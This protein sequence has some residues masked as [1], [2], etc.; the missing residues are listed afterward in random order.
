MWEALSWLVQ[1]TAVP[2]ETVKLS[3]VKLTMSDSGT[4]S[5][6]PGVIPVVTAGCWGGC[7]ADGEAKV[8]GQ[9][10]KMSVGVMVNPD[11][12]TPAAERMLLGL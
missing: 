11:A 7:F 6:G 2:T 1:V 4:S 8:T 9:F 12:L 5:L 3:K 10:I